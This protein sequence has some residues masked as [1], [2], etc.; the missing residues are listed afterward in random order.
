MESEFLRA[1]N[2][3]YVTDYNNYIISGGSDDGGGEAAAAD[4]SIGHP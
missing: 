2:F 1:C 3:K 4:W